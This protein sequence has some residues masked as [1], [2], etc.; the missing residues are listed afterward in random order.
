[1]DPDEPGP[2]RAL[3]FIGLA[4]LQLVHAFLSRSHIKTVFSRY[5]ERTCLGLTPMFRNIISNR[6][7]LLGVFV[8]LLSLIGA[9]Y[10]PFLRNILHQWPLHAWD[11]LLIL[12]AVVAHITI[13]EI[14]KVIVRW[15]ISVEK[16]KHTSQ[17]FFTEV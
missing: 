15:R 10:I 11:W 7:L 17:H 8:S 9:L 5:Y 4:V 3:A 12:G 6:W 13:V 1:M 16:R 2:A 14:I